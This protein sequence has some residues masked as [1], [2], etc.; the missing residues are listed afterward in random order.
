MLRIGTNF[1]KPLA[2]LMTLLA[3]IIVLSPAALRADAC[4]D[5]FGNCLSDLAAYALNPL[6]LMVCVNGF[7]FC[8][9]YLPS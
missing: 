8:L 1:R 9:A 5:A 3:V 2:W 7:I 6:H 4:W